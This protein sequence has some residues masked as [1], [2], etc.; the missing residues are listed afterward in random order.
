MQL[1]KN[2]VLD[3]HADPRRASPAQHS[4][5]LPI[6]KLIKKF[7][8]NDPPPQPK[9]A[10]PVLTIRAIA[11]QYTFGPHHKAVVDMVVVAFFYLLWVGEYTNPAQARG[12]KRTVLLRIVTCRY[13]TREFSWTM[14]LVSMF[15]CEQTAQLSPSHTPRM[16]QKGLSS[17]M[18][19]SVVRSARW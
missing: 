16:A 1:P 15:S 7:S 5:N 3:G 4:L 6:A 18:M 2:Y 13:G 11:T 9:L 19:P 14:I 10:V 12:M 8:D 17:T